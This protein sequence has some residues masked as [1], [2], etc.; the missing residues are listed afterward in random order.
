MCAEA[1]RLDDLEGERG[2]DA[3]AQREILIEAR[4][5]PAENEPD[6]PCAVVLME[7]TASAPPQYQ[8][9]QPPS[10]SR[11]HGFSR[12]LDERAL[13]WDYCYKMVNGKSM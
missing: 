1:G 13:K 7:W 6:G 5:L 11:W 9:R 3:M 10:R 4:E 8:T 2:R 12:P